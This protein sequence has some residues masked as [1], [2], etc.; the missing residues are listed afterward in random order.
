LIDV[1]SRVKLSTERYSDHIGLV[2]SAMGCL[3]LL[4]AVETQRQ[5][6]IEP[7]FSLNV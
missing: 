5:A 2:D 3:E 6:Y 7:G 1:L 4:L